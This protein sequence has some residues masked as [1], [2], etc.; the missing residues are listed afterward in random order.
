MINP[1]NN[2]NEKLMYKYLI[3]TRESKMSDDKQKNI[4][5]IFS[6]KKYKREE[7]INI[8]LDVMLRLKDDK[9]ATKSRKDFIDSFYKTMTK[10][11]GFI[12]VRNAETEELKDSNLVY[13]TLKDVINENGHTRLRY[14]NIISDQK[15]TKEEF[16]KLRADAEKEISKESIKKEEKLRK[17]SNY[18]IENKGFI[19]VDIYVPV[20][21]RFEF[22]F[23][24]EMFSWK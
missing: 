16:E 8:C 6:R 22:K 19:G 4:I 13:Y 23:L 9:T 7:F 3:R 12:D 21:L 18:L 11:F 5:A 14:L 17:V 15:Y 10:E 24:E 20:D 2:F 1:S